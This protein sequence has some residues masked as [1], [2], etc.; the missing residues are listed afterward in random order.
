M[1]DFYGFFKAVPRPRRQGEAKLKPKRDD[2]SYIET[3]QR[4]VLFVALP[5]L[6]I[7]HL[8]PT[9]MKANS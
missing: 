6:S 8:P 2:Y 4:L 9:Q 7:W 1:H 5:A 3:S